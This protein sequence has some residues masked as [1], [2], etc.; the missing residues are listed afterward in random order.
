MASFSSTECA[1]TV[2][3]ISVDLPNFSALAIERLEADGCVLLGRVYDETRV[4][5][6]L[7]VLRAGLEY[8]GAGTSMRDDAVGLYAARNVLLACPAIVELWWVAPL[9]EFLRHVLG[10]SPGL[11]R[12]LYFDKPPGRT[13]ALPWHRDVTIAVAKALPTMGRFRMPTRK[14]G[15]HHVE[16][17][18]EVIERMLTLRVH[19]DPMT[20][21]NGSLA[22]IPGSHRSDEEA[23]GRA[24]SLA[25][26]EA[27]DVLAMRGWILHASG[28]SHDRTTQHRRVLHLEFAADSEP[29]DGYEWDAFH[30][31]LAQ[32]SG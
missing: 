18:R 30:P 27:G 17:P 19:L 15:V 10:N 29:G 23:T 31:I 6:L 22:V 2:P 7:D 9:S 21:D 28:R 1:A 12:A 16:A 25:L 14:G 13:W 11:V 32:E 5:T 3:R 24:V 4:A 8:T 20:R 26:S